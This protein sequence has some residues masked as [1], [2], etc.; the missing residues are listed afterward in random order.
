MT[1]CIESLGILVGLN[2]GFESISQVVTSNVNLMESG[3]VLNPTGNG[4]LSSIFSLDTDSIEAVNG[5]TAAGNVPIAGVSIS[6]NLATDSLND[7]RD[8]INDAGIESVV[9][10]VNAVGPA[11]YA[12]EIAGTTDI[13][14]AG[15]VF[16]V[17]GIVEPASSI[18]AET[19]FVDITSSGVK[20]GDTI[21]ISGLNNAGDQVFG[22]AYSKNA[23]KVENLLNSIERTFGNSVV[24][25]INEEGRIIVRDESSG[26][27]S[28]ALS[29]EA[30]NEGGGLSLGEMARTTTGVDSRS[31][32]LQAGQD[33]KFLVM[34]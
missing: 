8:K 34:N 5:S 19:Q 7:I 28:F 16:S 32:E 26:S 33:A 14:D 4:A 30:N 31:A 25:S 11:K 9:A 18:T 12:L 24:A 21:S 13:E 17:L 29:L 1:V 6:L 10:K 2:N 15:G 22:T 20:A 3:D 27:S 23:V